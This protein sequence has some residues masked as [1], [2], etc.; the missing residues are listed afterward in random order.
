VEFKKIYMDEWSGSLD[1]TAFVSLRKIFLKAVQDWM[2]R[3]LSDS[4]A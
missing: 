1:H 4:K 3:Q 2:E